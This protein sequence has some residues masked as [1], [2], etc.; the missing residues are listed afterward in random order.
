[1]AIVINMLPAGEYCLIYQIYCVCGLYWITLESVSRFLVHKQSIVSEFCKHFFIYLFFPS[2]FIYFFVLAPF[3]FSSSF[4]NF[5]SL[6]FFNLFFSI[7][8]SYFYF[9]FL[10]YAIV[11]LLLSLIFFNCFFILV[12][13]LLLILPMLLILLITL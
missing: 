7:Y 9:F 3:V 13:V 4:I 11:F 5:L 2:R 6:I 8:F 1:M 10:S 12:L